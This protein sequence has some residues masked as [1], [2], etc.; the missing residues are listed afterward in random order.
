MKTMKRILSAVLLL[1]MLLCLAACGGKGGSKG[2]D[3]TS[4]SAKPE[5]TSTQTPETAYTA[6]HTP[7]SLDE[8]HQAFSPYSPTDD[9]F[10]MG[11]SVKTGENAPEGA[12]PEYE[13]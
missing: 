13:G 7:L 1:S 2:S 6:R 11:Y 3:Q 8:A 10:Y 4:P 12:V 5:Q 9:G